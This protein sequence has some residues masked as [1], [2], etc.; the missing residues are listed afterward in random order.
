M[1]QRI[2]NKTVLVTG[3][4][5]FIG[6]N[7]C[8]SL[9]NNGNKV[10]CLDNLSTGF[11][12]N[13]DA[14]ITDDNFEF[15]E[16]DIRNLA[17]CEKAV[18]GCDIVL[19]QAAL[20]SV[21][22]SI[23]DPLTTNSV[24]I[25][26]FLN[27]L[28]AVKNSNVNRFVYAASSSTYGDSKEL[29]KVEDRI[30]KPMSPYAV[31]KYVNELYANVYA[32]LYGV[33]V[34][35]LRYFNVFGKH[36]TPDGAYAAAIPRFIQAFIDKKSPLIFGDGFQTRDFT[37]IENVILANNLAATVG[38]PQALNQVYNVAFGQEIS[39][40]ELVGNI[41][42]ALL[43][44]IPEIANIEPVHEPPRAGDVAHSLASIEKARNLLGYNPVYS[45][46]KGLEEAIQWY[47]STLK[48]TT[49][50]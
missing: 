15:I 41:K 18:V 13:I 14:F 50:I 7:L 30:G 17:D 29:P 24:N 20:G 49:V 23:N 47:W 33:E 34:I 9:L 27:M 48:S 25:M 31:T 40:N 39:I 3:G 1:S 36:Q 46:E 6:T 21:P 26:G 2:Q 11:K 45:L 5:G 42:E 28:E 19:H 4:A 35:G 22:R 38:D 16:G 37:Y 8:E 10:V 44:I 12:A 32:D 43:N